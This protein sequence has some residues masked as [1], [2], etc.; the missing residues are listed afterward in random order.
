ME[1]YTMSKSN[2]ILTGITGEYLVAAELSKRGFTASLTLKNSKSVDILAIDDET[3]KLLGIQV[4]TKAINK[5]RW[6]L[7]EKSESLSAE[8][9]YYVF[10]NLKEQGLHEYH[11]VPSKTVAKAVTER[12]RKFREREG[13]KYEKGMRFFEDIENKYLNKWDLLRR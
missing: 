13:K 4:K 1:E 5:D 3:H 10:V 6:M 9:L 12:D 8:N 7:N 2:N 11:I